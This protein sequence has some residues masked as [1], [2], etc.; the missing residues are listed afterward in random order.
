LYCCRCLYARKRPEMS[1]CRWVQIS[2]YLAAAS[3]KVLNRVRTHKLLFLYFR[4]CEN[5]RN[6]L[7]SICFSV[8]E[9][10]R[11]DNW[12]FLK[13]K[14]LHTR[15]FWKY[16]RLPESSDFLNH[17]PLHVYLIFRKFS[18]QQS[19]K[20][21]N[22]I[23]ARSLVVRLST[24]GYLGSGRFCR[25]AAAPYI[26]GNTSSYFLQPLN[27]RIFKL[28]NNLHTKHQNS[29]GGRG[30]GRSI[31]ELWYTLQDVFLR[32]IFFHS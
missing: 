15:K 23:F 20:M 19:T 9:T 2:G 3:K 11:D 10:C 1:S 5:L 28:T 7:F 27:N 29:L 21:R 16:S 24:L 8:P 12:H 25:R 22:L 31:W 13:N 14:Y 32:Y 26:P 4:K 17:L 18:L 30:M 6:F